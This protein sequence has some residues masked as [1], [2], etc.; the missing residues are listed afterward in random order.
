MGW[1][2]GIVALLLF[3]TAVFYAA[4][5]QGGGTGY[6]AVMSLA[7][8]PPEWMKPTSLSLNILVAAIGTWKFGRGG[9]FQPKL[10]F[11]LVLASVPAAFIGGRLV[12]EPD[13]YRGLVTIVVGWAAYRL[14]KHTLTAVENPATHTR[15]W[16]IA[17]PMGGIIGF[18]SGLIGI[19]GGI[20]LAPALLL[21]RL[22]NTHQTFSL[23]AAF[24]LLNSIA[25]LLGYR[26]S[27]QPLPPN[28]PLWLTAVAVGG[29]LGA[30]YGSRHLN[31]RQ[32]RR[33]LAVMLLL[34]ILRL[35]LS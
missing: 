13:L 15:P 26:T 23:T 14:W 6:L 27:G 12:V 2:D 7:G 3:T 34:G 4:V 20:F 11:P 1:S 10:F 33:L 8:V 19:G 16:L 9:H 24:I 31:P 21:T 18:I 30:E 32:L 22:A 25:G 17:L 5:G 35:W 29:W 28:L